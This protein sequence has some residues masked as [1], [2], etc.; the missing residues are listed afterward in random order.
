M[1]NPYS[2]HSA[3]TPP[4]SPHALQLRRGFPRLR[5]E[6]PLEEEFR[7][8]HRAETLPQV[9]RNLWLG[10]GFLLVFAVLTHFVLA[11]ST[12]IRLDLIRAATF[13]PV[14]VA[15][16]VVVYSR[17]YDRFYPLV[18]MIGALVFGAG[19]VAIAVLAAREGVSLISAIVLV[20]IYIYFMLGM[21][22]YPALTAALAVF[23]TYALGAHVADLPANTVVIDL[24]VLAFTNVVGAIVSYSLERANRTNFL[25]ERL[26]IETASRDGL[27]GIHNRRFFDEHLEKVWSQA[28]RERVPLALLLVDIDHFKAYNDCYG[29]QAGDECLRKVAW[30]LSRAAR[31]PLDVTARYGGEEFAIVLYDARR[32]HAEE[33][34]L[35]IRSGIEALA[36]AHAASPEREKRLTVSIGVACIE[37]VV[38]RS[39][40]GFVQLADEAL[41]AAK[42]RGRNRVVIMDKE[43]EQLSTGSFRG[44]ADTPDLHTVV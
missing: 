13:A 40:H 25:E 42:E 8:A 10:I 22:F 36:I 35:R 39:A 15:M 2:Q 4:E 38:G 3:G 7:R 34:A 19:A 31:R 6:A 26:L 14:V 17:W 23:L 43:Y 16:V 28:T 37:P 44:S 18:A 33:V 30:C 5:F 24:V 20:T 29:H 21:T 41:Y 12:S 32:S 1:S 27:T 11:P 9:R